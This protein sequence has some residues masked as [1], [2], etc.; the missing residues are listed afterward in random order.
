MLDDMKE[1][2]NETN[3]IIER[4]EANLVKRFSKPGVNP[5][6]A[7]RWA[8]WDTFKWD[9]FRPAIFCYFSELSAIC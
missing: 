6:Q 7:T 3:Q 1:N 2:D 9:I 4:L 8:I 5:Y